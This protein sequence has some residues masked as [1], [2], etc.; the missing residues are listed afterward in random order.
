MKKSI[1]FCTA[2]LLLAAASC[3]GHKENDGDNSAYTTLPP[4]GT[5]I[6]ADSM[7]VTEDPLNHFTFS[8]KVKANNNTKY[9]VYDVEASWG[10][11]TAASQFTMPRG[12]EKLKP[13]LRKG[14]APYTYIIGFHYDKDTAFYDYYQVNGNRGTIE[15]KYLKGYS[16]K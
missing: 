11:N 16:F 1:L 14:T 12:G 6:V 2:I 7:K 10:P 13:V 15:A 5:T 4:A 8:V 3:S 9:G